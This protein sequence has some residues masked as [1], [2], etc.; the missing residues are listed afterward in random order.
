MGDD[1]VIDRDLRGRMKR[2]SFGVV[3]GGRHFRNCFGGSPAPIVKYGREIWNGVCSR[4]F[5]ASKNSTRE[6][7]TDSTVFGGLTREKGGGR[8]EERRGKR[9][10]L[11]LVN[12][13]TDG[14]DDGEARNNTNVNPT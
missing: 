12:E 5:E 3:E 9:R 6:E 4:S 8:F 10:S 1:T 11:P 2:D 7:K 14:G 13:A